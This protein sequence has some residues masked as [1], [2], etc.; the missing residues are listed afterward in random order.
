MMPFFDPSPPSH[1]HYKL[2]EPAGCYNRKGLVVLVTACADRF[3]TSGCVTICCGGIIAGKPIGETP[4]GTAAT[5]RP[6]TGCIPII[7][8]TL[9]RGIPGA[10]GDT[11]TMGDTELYGIAAGVC[12]AGVTC[13]PIDITG[14]ERS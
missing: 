2:N 5:G 7:G 1:H 9:A 12:P 6:P 11:D 14:L 8:D 10:I 4:G 13:C 3:G